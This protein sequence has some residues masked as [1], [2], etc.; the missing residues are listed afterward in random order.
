MAALVVVGAIV[1]G[2]AVLY[3]TG[4]EQQETL[5]SPSPLFHVYNGDDVPHEVNVTVFD[6][7]ANRTSAPLYSEAYWLETGGYAR[8]PIKHGGGGEYRFEISVDGEDPEEFTFSLPHYSFL[9]ISVQT[10]GAIKAL[11]AQS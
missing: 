9:A 7:N 6:A 11:M 3:G 5:P 4:Q 2:T 1:V 10:E 8:P